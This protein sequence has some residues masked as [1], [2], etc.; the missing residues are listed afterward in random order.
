MS[1]VRPDPVAADLLLEA[2]KQDKEKIFQFDATVLDRYLITMKVQQ[3]LDRQDSIHQLA[4][5]RQGCKWLL[6]TE[7]KIGGNSKNK[8]DEDEKKDF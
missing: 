3:H 1:V 8:G 5:L 2:A 7:Q 6:K 4:E